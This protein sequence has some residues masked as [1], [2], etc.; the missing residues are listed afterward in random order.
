MTATNIAIQQAGNL[1]NK[2]GVSGDPQELVATLKETA[3]KGQV[4]DAQFTALMIVAGQYGLNPF[5]NEIYAFPSNGSIV[6]VVGVS[7]KSNLAKILSAI[8]LFVFKIYSDS[9]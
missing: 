7:I 8:F 9:K 3:F 4:S 6:P 5:T 1:A 2:F